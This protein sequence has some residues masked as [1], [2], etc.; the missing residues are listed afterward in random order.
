MM[1]DT[2]VSASEQP[3][4]SHLCENCGHVIEVQGVW[5]GQNIACP[6]CQ[7]PAAL[8]MAN[9]L[10]LYHRQCRGC[11]ADVYYSG[12]D[13]F[14]ELSCPDC[15]SIVAGIR[16]R[17]S[18]FNKRAERPSSKR[19]SHPR[20]GTVAR[21]KDMGF[22]GLGL[23]RKR[24]LKKVLAA[25]AKV[26]QQR[27][28]ERR[29]LEEAGRITAIAE[30]FLR[31][32]HPDIEALK[33][34]SV[35]ATLPP[36]RS[37]QRE[38]QKVTA[39][40]VAQPLAS[41]EPQVVPVIAP[42][43]VQVP[44]PA[45]M[46]VPVAVSEPSVPAIPIPVS[47]VPV[48]PEVPVS[49]P[50]S[51][52][53][54]LATAALPPDEN[55]ELLR[56]AKEALA[57][58]LPDLGQPLSQ[59]SSP[60]E[61]QTPVEP[62]PEPVVAVS[63]PV[64]S[65]VVPPDDLANL[66]FVPT[67]RRRD[68]GVAPVLDGQM[69][70]GSLPISRSSDVPSSLSEPDEPA[71]EHSPLWAS[72]KFAVPL[73]L[74]AGIIAGAWWFK[75]REKRAQMA[76]LG[77]S[78][79]ADYRLYMKGREMAQAGRFDEALALMSGRVGE[80]SV[81][82]VLL[83]FALQIKAALRVENITPSLVVKVVSSGKDGATQAAVLLAWECLWNADGATRLRAAEALDAHYGDG[84]MKLL[85]GRLD[86]ALGARPEQILGEKPAGYDELEWQK[87]AVHWHALNAR[88]GNARSLDTLRNWAAPAQENRYLR[89]NASVALLENGDHSI[90]DTALALFG[91]LA[92][93]I[94]YRV[95]ETERLG[96][97]GPQNPFGAKLKK[98]ATVDLAKSVA[99]THRAL[100]MQEVS[101]GM[102]RLL[103]SARTDALYG[104]L[105]IASVVEI[106]RALG[107]DSGRSLLSAKDYWVTYQEKLQAEASAANSDENRVFLG[108]TKKVLK[109]IHYQEMRLG[110]EEKREAIEKEIR[111]TP[112]SEKARLCLDMAEAGVAV[113]SK[114]AAAMAEGEIGAP[115]TKVEEK[116]RA[117]QIL[118][119]HGPEAV[120]PWL[121]KQLSSSDIS[122][123]YRAA[124]RLLE[125][126]QAT[127]TQSVARK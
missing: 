104:E 105:A 2:H 24:K 16:A 14:K 82:P 65:G 25:R 9:D 40:P 34:P 15:R 100:Y 112:E 57:P 28:Q 121:V 1:S 30:A 107:E 33:V 89:E 54:Q 17:K 55:Q 73:L 86:M 56:L 93:A 44:E 32:E 118:L 61:T 67:R 76:T 48:I 49:Q 37:T 119:E 12:Q 6:H 58:P 27:A 78:D 124:L 90:K 38:E 23:E 116:N 71:R 18:Q 84:E 4:L 122:I 43:L 13:E 98:W 62:V 72:L 19:T 31:G 126:E 59:V 69:P 11:G 99:A 63:H 109:V 125:L 77:F 106:V 74:L 10:S 22:L 7:Y 75:E 29:A 94:A 35:K 111:A 52:L 53:P 26:Q 39:I 113:A 85:S 96:G 108:I 64:D 60:P 102:R 101:E 66:P 81:D 117:V 103:E 95:K 8:P 42:P 51:L 87:K 97:P 41:P 127:R 36:T 83:S 5:S 115:P 47:P 79:Y 68:S 92:E 46:P 88:R 21:E 123:C 20:P 80:P 70:D 110:E 120:R 50:A 3:W 114:V 91:E 45:V